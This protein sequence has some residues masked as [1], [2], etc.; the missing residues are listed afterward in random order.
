MGL[1]KKWIGITAGVQCMVGT[2]HFTTGLEEKESD[3]NFSLPLPWQLKICARKI[4]Q[5]AV[6]VRKSICLEYEIIILSVDRYNFQSAL[7]IMNTCVSWILIPTETE[8]KMMMFSVPT[9][10]QEWSWTLPGR[11][12]KEEEEED[13]REEDL[14]CQTD[15]IIAIFYTGKKLRHAPP[16]N[17]FI[18]I[19]QGSFMCVLIGWDRLPA[20]YLKILPDWL[21]VDLLCI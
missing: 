18:C 5:T 1:S 12:R 20:A 10:T 2:R 7:M 6:V 17:P 15:I 14:S 3:D 13:F 19:N 21:W 9:P 4:P 11:E 8:S 16:P